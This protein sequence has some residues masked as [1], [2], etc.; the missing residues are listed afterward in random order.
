[1]TLASFTNTALILAADLPN[2]TPDAPPGASGFTT[3]LNWVAW[4]VF[5]AAL[6]GFLGSL[7][8]MAFAAMTGRE[9]THVKGL[10]IAIV[11]CILAGSAGA[12]IGMFVK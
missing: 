2:I 9:M 6:I 7:A 10:F 1:M 3:I 4:F 5:F 8:F 12:I 11:V